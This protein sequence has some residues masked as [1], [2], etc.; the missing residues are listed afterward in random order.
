MTGRLLPLLLLVLVLFI[1]FPGLFLMDGVLFFHDIFHHHYPWRAFNGILY[2]D[3]SLPLWNPLG[4]CGFPMLADG[5]SGPLYPPNIILFFLFHPLVACNLLVIG[6]FLMAGFFTYALCRKLGLPRPPSFLSSAVYMISGF[7]VSHLTFM[8]MMSAYPWLPLALLLIEKGRRRAIFI[9]LAGV[10]V[11]VQFTA[12]HPQIA[13]YSLMAAA[14]YTLCRFGVRPRRFFPA[15]AI[16]VFFSLTIPAA[17]LLPTAELTVRSVREGAESGFLG[18]GSFPPFQAINF[19][20]PHFFGFDSPASVPVS[21]HMEGSGYWGVGVN[22]WEFCFYVGVLPLLLAFAAPPKRAG[23]F[24]ALAAVSFLLMLGKYNPLYRLLMAVPPF[25][26]FRFPARFGYVLTF[27]LAILSGYG[28]DN[29]LRNRRVAMRLAVIAIALAVF[30]AAV[31]PLS[32]AVLNR[33]SGEIEG[34]LR[35]GLEP[36]KLERALAFIDGLGESTRLGRPENMLPIGLLALAAVVFASSRRLPGTLAAVLIIFIS[37]ADLVAFARGY[38]PVT[39]AEIALR[40]PVTA[41]SLPAP[42]GL[43]RIT[44]LDRHVPVAFEKEL[45]TA[46]YGMLFN[47]P[48]IEYPSPLIPKRLS[49]LIDATGTSLAPLPPE[50]SMRRMEKNRKLLD[51]LNVRFVI[52]VHEI[53]VPGFRR[54]QGGR[55]KV[56]ENERCLSRAF[57]VGRATPVAAEET[58][59]RMTGPSFDPRREVL[60]DD[61]ALSAPVVEY[62]AAGSTCAVIRY[63]PDRVTIEADSPRGGWLVLTD[64]WYPGWTAEI[65]GEEAPVYRADYVFRAVELSP[66]SHTVEFI[67]RPGSFR[68]GARVSL[69]A[70]LLLLVWASVPRFRS[71]GC[72]Q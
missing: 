26:L 9:A 38:N 55:V 36:P 28:L 51:L 15:L 23:V 29:L 67:Y 3:F 5:Q 31:L 43:W 39:P 10:V 58:L 12:G 57:I 68:W 7:A 24:I 72:I 34:K 13:S 49:S 11:G 47:V 27:S 30:F 71:L 8:H 63:L 32:H 37:L 45:L 6:H 56:Y 52:T 19:I 42:D 44:I 59:A 66:G 4:G 16:L 48:D 35:A 22:Y 1:I 41:G 70:L 60:L 18:W 65:D 46:S 62:D 20:F 64:T 40:G 21:Y 61:G 53:D 69:A 33:R 14:F 54:I 50:E 17:Q 25:S 2:R